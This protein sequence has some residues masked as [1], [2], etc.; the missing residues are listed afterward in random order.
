MGDFLN[1]SGARGHYSIFGKTSELLNQINEA[2][3]A[4]EKSSKL[5]QTFE[6]KIQQFPYETIITKSKSGTKIK[7]ITFL[8][9]I[10]FT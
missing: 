2:I 8:F 3:L 10:G 5:L 9:S 4:S 6:K 1:D 7:N